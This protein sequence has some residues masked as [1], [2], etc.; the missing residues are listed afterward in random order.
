MTATAVSTTEIDLAWTDNATNE[1][2]FKIERSINGVNFTQIASVGANVVNGADVGLNPSTTYYYRVRAFNATGDSD[3]SNIA[4]A[5]TASPPPP[6]P[7]NLSASA[8]DAQVVL[9]WDA[10]A[11]AMSYNVKRGT[12]SG[13]PYTTASHVNA[14]GGKYHGV[15]YNARKIAALTR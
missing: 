3:Y 2:G 4:S 14:R 12:S 1:D 7:G 15:R 13:G 9:T 6:A 10:S 5:T 11:G 8:G